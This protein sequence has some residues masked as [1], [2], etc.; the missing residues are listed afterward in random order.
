MKNWSVPK[1]ILSSELIT[2]NIAKT[3]ESALKLDFGQ[4]LKEFGVVWSKCGML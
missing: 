4:K 1:I 3:V 2:V